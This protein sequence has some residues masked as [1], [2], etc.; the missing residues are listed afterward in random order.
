[1]CPYSRPCPRRHVD[2]AMPRQMGNH[3]RQN[4]ISCKLEHSLP[5]TP[6]RLE[7]LLRFL[8]WN[9]GYRPSRLN[10]EGD[11]SRTQH[12]ARLIAAA[13]E[14]H[15]VDIVV[16]AESPAPGAILRAMQGAKPRFRLHSHPIPTEGV[17]LF[18]RL[19]DRCVRGIATVGRSSGWSIRLPTAA[20]QTS[21]LLLFGLHLQSKLYYSEGDQAAAS[22]RINTVIGATE[23]AKGHTRTLAV[24]DFNMNPFESGMIS[25][26]G[27]HAVPTK[28][29]ARKATRKVN[30]E[31]VHF[32]YNPMWRHFGDRP[33]RS[34]GTYYKWQSNP[35][36]YF[37]HI[38]DQ[39]LIRPSLLQAF[40]DDSLAILTD[41][42]GT[43]LL[44]DAGTPSAAV[45]SDHLPIIFVLDEQEF[46]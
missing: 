21:E 25:S 30:G 14:Q 34:A 37:W 10:S 38:F 2:G 15:G 46:E 28:A 3:W 11:R 27:F 41:I 39:V 33:N 31:D 24:G 6:R 12:L 40:R 32:F 1:M 45:A 43:P 35:L 17:R 22:V 36:A 26:A 16:I 20:R 4:T 29:I 18:S 5:R 23:Q 7:A 19:P 9:T 8:F 42:D 13:A 44:T